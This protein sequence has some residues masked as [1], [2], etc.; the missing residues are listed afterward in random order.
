MRATT[1]GD[2]LLLCAHVISSGIDNSIADPVMSLWKIGIYV[3][4]DPSYADHL[5]FIST[6]DALLERYPH[7]ARHK[8]ILERFPVL[9]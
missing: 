3:N 4:D 2:A 1:I 7:L 6:L 9:Y 5:G 8:A